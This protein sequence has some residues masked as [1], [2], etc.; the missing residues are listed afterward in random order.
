MRFAYKYYARLESLLHDALEQHS[1]DGRALSRVCHRPEGKR[2]TI[3]ALK[4][5][6][7]LARKYMAAE[8]TSTLS[9]VW[10]AEESIRDEKSLDE[11]LH[12]CLIIPHELHTV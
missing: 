12:R 9:K 10:R 6:G 1:F 5:C 4:I 7:G 2:Y 3:A 11:I 8:A